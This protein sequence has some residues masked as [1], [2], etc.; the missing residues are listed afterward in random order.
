MNDSAGREHVHGGKEILKDY[1]HDIKSIYQ[2]KSNIVDFDPFAC[3]GI[4]TFFIFL[5]REGV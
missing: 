4:L 5:G 2:C 3:V 1:L